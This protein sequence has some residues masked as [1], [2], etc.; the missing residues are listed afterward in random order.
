LLK[1]ERFH[2]RD[3]AHLIR[4]P[5][6]VIDSDAEQ[7]MPGQAAELHDALKCPKTLFTFRSGEGAELHCQIGGRL[8]G[9][10]QIYDW[11]DDTLA[12]TS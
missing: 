4:C 8:L 12:R 3:C 1:Q 5:T 9:N 2:V 6:L 10:Q 11:L 7:F